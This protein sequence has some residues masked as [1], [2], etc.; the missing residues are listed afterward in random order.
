M[1]SYTSTQK[2]RTHILSSELFDSKQAQ[3]LFD[4]KGLSFGDKSALRAK[5]TIGGAIVN[6]DLDL[7]H[8]LSYGLSH[9]QLKIMK[10]SIF[11]FSATKKPFIA[12]AQYT[13]EPLSSGFMAQEY[14]HVYPQQSAV[15]AESLGRGQIIGFADNLLFRNIWLGSEKIYAN[16]LF[17]AP[18]SL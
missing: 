12:S 14:Q 3:E 5:Q 9:P 2:S 7:T 4:T 1:W 11:S 10:N 18:S 17:F 16:A 8:P 15:I 13:K 6:I